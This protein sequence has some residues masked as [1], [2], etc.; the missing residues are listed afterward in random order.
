MVAQM[1][2]RK[3]VTKMLGRGGASPSY[4]NGKAVAARFRLLNTLRAYLI[5]L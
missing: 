1:R 4:G 2:V 3:N 5:W